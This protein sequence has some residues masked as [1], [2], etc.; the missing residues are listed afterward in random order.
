MQEVITQL[1]AEG[2]V[3]EDFPMPLGRRNLD[4]NIAAT[5]RSAHCINNLL[6]MGP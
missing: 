2:W 5:H 1:K 4:L 3:I 6:H